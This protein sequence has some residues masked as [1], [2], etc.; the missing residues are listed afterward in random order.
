MRNLLVFLL[1]F[2]SASFAQTTPSIVNKVGVPVRI[3]SITATTS[4]FLAAVTVQN[5][6]GQK[7]ESVKLG[8]LMNVPEG[9]AIKA[10][11]GP[12]RVFSF[13]VSLDPNGST[14]LNHLGLL[15]TEVQ[16]L[17]KRVR[18]TDTVSQIAVTE[19]TYVGGAKWTLRRDKQSYDDDML[20]K[21]AEVRCLVKAN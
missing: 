3:V 17:L 11:Q 2:T 1:T 21:T 14:T 19:V 10:Y 9:C 18:G 20:V 7:V 8:L 16:A 15:P 4:D 12:E 6:S 5:S 13:T